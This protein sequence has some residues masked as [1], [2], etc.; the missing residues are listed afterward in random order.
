[1]LNKIS[2]SFVQKDFL[3]W[4]PRQD[5]HSFHSL[6]FM[7]DKTFFSFFDKFIFW[8]GR[9]R[10]T[11]MR[12]NVCFQ[13]VGEFLQDVRWNTIIS[14]QKSES[15]TKNHWKKMWSYRTARKSGTEAHVKGVYYFYVRLSP[16]VPHGALT[17][18]FFSSPFLFFFFDSRHGIYTEKEEVLVVSNISH[19]KHEI[20]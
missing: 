4:S 5:G 9:S 3:G 19:V 17:L 20:R 10:V 13:C 16:R 18:I 1:M 12:M 2:W 15:K 8:G 14:G 11:R 7:V 6:I